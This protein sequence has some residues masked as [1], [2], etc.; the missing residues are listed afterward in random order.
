MDVTSYTYKRLLG[1]KFVTALPSVAGN[2]MFTAS[3]RC[4]Y[5]DNDPSIVNIYV[6]VATAGDVKL[7]REYG[8]THVWETLGT[9]TASVSKWYSIPATSGE[10][11]NL[12]Y[13]A[14][15]Y[16]INALYVV[17]TEAAI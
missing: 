9:Q 5:G 12:T 7:H 4:N 11:L 16:N 17:Q 10:Y 2:D 13:T 15:G 6:N 14:T 3:L 1:S 8:G